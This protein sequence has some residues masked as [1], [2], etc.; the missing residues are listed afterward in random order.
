MTT[1]LNIEKELE[2][3]REVKWGP[4]T[5]DLDIIFYDNVI[6]NDVHVILPH[7]LMHLR[8]FVLEPL[9]EIAPYALHPLKQKR[10]FE[11]LEELNE[12]EDKQI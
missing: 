12:K 1:L 8:G 5:I 9:N 6:S 10:V 4:R 11:L 3:V 2:R 7:P